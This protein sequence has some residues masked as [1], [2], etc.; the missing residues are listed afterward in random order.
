MIHYDHRHLA[1]LLN[2]LES[3]LAFECLEEECDASSFE[4]DP[5]GAVQD[6]PRK[7]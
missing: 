7:A 5:N 1:P 2:Q 3:H 4:P 6:T